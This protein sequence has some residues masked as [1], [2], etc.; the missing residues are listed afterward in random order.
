MN[1]ALLDADRGPR[2]ALGVKLRQLRKARGWTQEDLADRSAYSPTHISAIETGRK[3][4]TLRLSRDL[5]RIFGLS[6]DTF[7]RDFYNLRN[8]ALLEGFAAYVKEEERAVE[9]RLFEIG[10]VPGLLQTP[11]YAR[12]LAEADVWRGLIT[13]GQAEHRL[14]YLAKRQASLQRLRPPMMLVIMDESCLRH[15]VGSEGVMQE[16]FEALAAFAARPNAV[17]QVAPHAL[18]QARPF[19]LPVYLLT[20]AD[21]SQVG[22]AESQIQGQMEREPSR[23]LGIR[24]AYHHLM[25]EA[26]SPSATVAL[27]TQARKGKL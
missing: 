8:G 27:I 26:L 7:E 10:L 5:D 1:E 9:I 16:Q 13:E 12:A 11:A 4:P 20:M 22:Y 6:E 19:N 23:L 18:G 25:A 2:E 17:L 21:G 14:T 3:P 15:R 24:A